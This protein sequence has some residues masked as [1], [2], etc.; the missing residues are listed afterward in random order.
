MS[1]VSSQSVQDPDHFKMKA[2]E[3]I[4]EVTETL[5]PCGIESAE[6]EAELILRYGLQ[7]DPVILYSDNPELN[8]EEELLIRQMMKRRSEREPLQY[9]V[10]TVEFMGLTIYVGRGVLIPRPET[11]LMAEHAIKMLRAQSTENRTQN[12]GSSLSILDLC[13]GSGCLALSLASAFPDSQ[14][15]GTDVSGEALSY[16]RQNAA[17][18]GLRNASFF[19]SDLFSALVPKQSFDL[20]ISNPPYIKTEDIGNLQPEVRD[21]EPRH[22]L[23][24]GGDGLDYYR[25][26]V[27]GACNFLKK[28]GILMVELGDDSYPDV[29]EMFT[30][31]GYS[32]IEVMTDYSGKKR[33]LQGIWT[34]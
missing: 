32:G 22:A 15:Y 26:I 28:K 1:V 13:T 31:A 14:V 33:I 6:K 4:K 12:S 8:E 9:I 29:N 7:I 25:Q 3:K 19:L 34:R 10:G 17:S 23:D 5:S 16:A 2:I 24:G 21:W 27:S 18:N 11:E 20:I 30:M